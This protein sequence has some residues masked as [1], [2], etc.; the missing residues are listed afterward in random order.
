MK[1]A[2]EMLSDEH[3]N[4]LRLIDAMLEKCDQ[5]ENK[6]EIDRAFF[7]KAIDFIR[8]YADKFHHAKEEDIL[9]K[10]LCKDT[11]EMHCNPTE[12]MRYEHDTGRGFVRGME[13]ALN[14]N[15]KKKLIKNAR[16]Y[17][18]L[19]QQH[20]YKEDSILY[21]MAEDALPGKTKKSILDKFK[22]LENKKTIGK[23]NSILK[24]LEKTNK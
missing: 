8:N 16:D 18:E 7:E 10:E 22:K 6:K 4:I 13:E 20:I 19:L 23:Y 11:V 3:R 24:E 2:T 15:D 5:L 12:Q 1:T 9:F 17:A 21:P 14:K